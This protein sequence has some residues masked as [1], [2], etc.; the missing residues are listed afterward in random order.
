MKKENIVYKI[1]N[2]WLFSVIVLSVMVSSVPVEAEDYEPQATSHFS[3]VPSVTSVEIGDGFYIWSYL[4][5]NDP[6]DSWAIYLLEYNESSLGMATVTGVVEGDWFSKAGF[7]S[8]GTINN[9][10]CNIKNPQYMTSGTPSSSNETLVRWNLT[11]LECGLLYINL[12]TVDAQ[13]GGVPVTYDT[14]NTTVMIYP[15]DPAALLATAYNHTQ[16]NITFTAGTGDDKVTI[17]GKEGSYPTGPTDNLLYNGTSSPQ[18]DFPLTPCTDYYY[19]AWGW[20]ETLGVH[21]LTNRSSSAKTQCY[22]NFTLQ[23]EEPNDGNT[24]ANCTYSVPVSVQVINTEA[25]SFDYWINASNGQTWDATG[26]SLP[27][28]IGFTL[29]SLS[30]NTSYWWNVTVTDGVGDSTYQ[31]YSFTTGYGSGASPSATIGYPSNGATSASINFNKFNVTPTDTDGDVLDVYFYWS[32]STLIGSTVNTASGTVAE[33]TPT[34]NLAY[35]TTYSWYTVVNDTCQQ[36]RVPASG[37]W[38][39][40]TDEPS[41][42]VTKEWDVNDN[43]SITGYINITNNGEVNLTGLNLTDTIDSHL[44][45]LGSNVSATYG[46]NIWIIDYLNMTESWGLEILLNLSAK[47]DNGTTVYNNITVTNSSY[48]LSASAQATPLTY[49]YYAYKE[50]NITVLE[51]NTTHVRYNITVTN[52]GDFP[53]HNVTI[54]EDFDANMTFYASNYGV[55]NPFDIGTINASHNGYLYIWCNTSYGLDPSDILVNGTTHYNN[56]TVATNEI[57]N[58]TESSYLFTGASTEAIRV[59]YDAYLTEVRDIGDTVIAIIGIVLVIGA[60]LMI[61]VV[62]KGY[63][64][65]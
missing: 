6:I 2:I 34:L 30:H 20:N 51:W 7:G 12:T 49:C 26:V 32:N 18:I 53:I 61:L 63:G 21:S 45:V 50:A 31:N 5:A 48:G 65:F 47:V 4:D 16:I 13:N 41:V 56:I 19:R 25:S 14:A 27:T 64:L 42:T 36:T 10:W 59:I 33:I 17:C 35:N 55:V 57:N 15:Q 22:T 44:T 43:S 28:T 9:T 58:I 3:V 46:D 37:Y 1:G 54:L 23:N 62:L 39:V 11:A 8:N 52:C 60:I 24:T 38:T 40:T 29:T